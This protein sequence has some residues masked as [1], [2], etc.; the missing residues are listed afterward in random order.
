MIQGCVGNQK[1]LFCENKTKMP[2]NTYPK[3]N[4]KSC[5]HFIIIG[6]P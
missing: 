4:D 3:P 1:K 6:I 2:S 5:H